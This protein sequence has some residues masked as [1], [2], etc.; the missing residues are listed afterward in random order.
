MKQQTLDLSELFTAK[1]IIESI[2]SWN[3]A[4]YKQEFNAKLTIDLLAEELDE[5][6]GALEEGNLIEL[7]DGL[8]DLFYVSI[9]AL[10]KFGY[11]AEEITTFLDEV[12]AG[13]QAKPP[14]PAAVHWATLEPRPY[15]IAI[16]ALAAL[17]D[18]TATLE[19]SD[20]AALDVIR[21][22]CES[23]DTKPAVKTASDTKANKDKGD[24]FV[25]PTE[26][27]KRIL[28]LVQKGAYCQKRKGEAKNDETSRLQ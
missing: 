24:S 14:T 17:D 20:E 5:T 4:R 7:L 27:I 19:G 2:C 3:A 16:V 1:T 15:A 25:P 28:T 8:G 10:W 6:L 12:E 26:K 21:A 9:G 11:S 22:I 13:L 23:N 18:L